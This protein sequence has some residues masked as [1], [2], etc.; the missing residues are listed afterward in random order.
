MANR[1]YQQDHVTSEFEWTWK[2]FHLRKH[3]FKHT[4]STVCTPTGW[5]W[6]RRRR[7]GAQDAFASRAPGFFFLS[8]KSMAYFYFYCTTQPSPLEPVFNGM[9]P[10]TLLKTTDGSLLKVCPP[11][12][13]L[14]LLVDGRWV[15]DTAPFRNTSNP[16]PRSIKLSHLCCEYL[17]LIL[18][19]FCV[20]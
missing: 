18:Q 9:K 16:L 19:W 5:R 11:A 4:Y 1:K 7:R 13:Q 3:A 20:H 14:A 12:L 17:I 8:F 6:Q 15:E 10:M 2:I